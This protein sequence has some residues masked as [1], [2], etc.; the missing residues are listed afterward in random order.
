M[1]AINRSGQ[2]RTVFFVIVPPAVL[3]MS[4]ALDFLCQNIV[5]LS[6]T[7]G[8]LSIVAVVANFCSLIT[9]LLG[10]VLIKDGISLATDWLWTDVT[11]IVVCL[12]ISLATEVS[13]AMMQDHQ[14]TAARGA[15][16]RDLRE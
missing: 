11:L 14:K 4:T 6:A 8:F 5:R 16:R 1:D 15:L 3:G 9:G 7:T 2:F 10:F 12:G 13:T